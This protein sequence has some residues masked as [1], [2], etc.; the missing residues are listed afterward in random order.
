MKTLKYKLKLEG[1]DSPSGTI[2]TRELSTF[3][4]QFTSCAERGLR[5]AIEG[6]SSKTGPAPKWLAK[7]T[8]FVFTGLQKGSTVLNIEAPYLKDAIPDQAVQQDIWGNPPKPGDTAISFI[9]RSVRD[10]STENLESDYYDSGVLMSFL[11]M[12]PFLTEHAKSIKIHC[13]ENKNEDFSIDMPTIEKVE[14]LKIKIPDPQAFML[15]GILEEVAYSRKR[16]RLDMADGQVIQGQIDQEFLDVEDL[17]RL[18]GKKVTIKGIVSYKP[19]GKVRLLE[20]QMLKLMEEGE[21]VFETAP[22]VQTE[23]EFTRGLTA[24]AV[25]RNWLDDIRG[26]WPGDESIDDLVRELED[27]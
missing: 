25:R 17:R 18:W 20:A 16:F 12:K 6:Q 5:L 1:L 13:E 24:E 14:K 23:F 8:D 10:T 15:T 7:A 22:V 19:S 9:S 3:L 11:A 2:S 27:R 21:E 4:E 26:K